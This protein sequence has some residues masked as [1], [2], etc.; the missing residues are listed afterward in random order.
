MDPLKTSETSQIIQAR[1][2]GLDVAQVPAVN[3]L[4]SLGIPEDYIESAVTAKAESRRTSLSPEDLQLDY[5]HAEGEIIAW[6]M[7]QW[8]VSQENAL[9]ILNGKANPVQTC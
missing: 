7:R 3:R 8:E 9:L 4:R 5:D 6:G 2:E 1:I